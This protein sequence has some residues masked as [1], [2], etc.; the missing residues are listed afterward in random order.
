V[1]SAAQYSPIKLITSDAHLPIPLQDLMNRI[2]LAETK[3]VKVIVDE[4]QNE[5]IFYC[6]GRDLKGTNS[7]T[8]QWTPEV[9]LKGISDFKSTGIYSPHWGP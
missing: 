1:P 5:Q 4:I 3:A 7:W 9:C 6:F 2:S 8:R